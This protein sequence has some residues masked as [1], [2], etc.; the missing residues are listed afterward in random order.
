MEEVGK[1]ETGLVLSQNPLEAALSCKLA[2][3]T[4][5]AGNCPICTSKVKEQVDA[6][7]E[8]GD[9]WLDIQKFLETNGDLATVPQIKYH[10][11]AHI[12][13]PKTEAALE[14]YVA[15]VGE[16]AK[17]GRSPLDDIRHLIAAE[18]MEWARIAVLETG[19]DSHREFQRRKMLEGISSTILQCHETVKRIQGEGKDKEIERVFEQT[20]LKTITGAKTSEEK[21]LLVKLSK[22]ILENFRQTK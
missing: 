9:S 12:I 4:G 13:N 21:D 7:L 20:L 14:E 1:V 6:K 2:A 3:R 22:D 15:G 16:M 11:E 8:K 10:K 5:R 19:G 18:W 17:R